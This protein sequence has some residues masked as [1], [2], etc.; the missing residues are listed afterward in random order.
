[1]P[2]FV[3]YN[4]LCTERLYFNTS[5]R[6]RGSWRAASVTFRAHQYL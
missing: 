3:D 4:S 5:W 2:L 6:G 1:L